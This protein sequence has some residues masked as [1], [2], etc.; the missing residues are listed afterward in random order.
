MILILTFSSQSEK[1]KF[2]YLYHTYKNLM[3]YK[4]HQ[5]LR[6]YTLSED[7]VSEAFIRIYKNIDKIDDPTSNSSAAFLVTI[8]KNTA[9]TLLS[10]EKKQAHTEF[11]EEQEFA[12]D[13]EHY[14]LGEIS[15]AEI[16]Q[17]VDTLNEDLKSVFLLS[18]SYQLSH[19]E[20]ARLLDI[21]ENNVTV[22]LHRAKK[23]LA[24]LL[25]K[26]GYVHETIK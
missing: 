18:Y 12:F 23:K 16:T 25:I 9:L 5:I 13:L 26:G 11:A 17:V 4:A 2:E 6:D 22:R 1:D 20:I 21:S 7:A 15:A 19:K 10:R 8:V 24:E 14:V 3:L